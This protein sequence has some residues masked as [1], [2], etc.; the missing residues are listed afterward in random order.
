MIVPRA[1]LVTGA[2]G[3]IGVALCRNLA[4]RGTRVLAHARSK[5]KAEVVGNG[6]IAVWGDVTRD[7]DV[8]AI[9][10]QVVGHGGV[11]LVVHNAGVL[12]RD[13]R[14][15]PHGLGIQGEVNVLAP[16]T[17]TV[18]LDRA[19]ALHEG[20]TV[21]VNTSGAANLAR[22]H[23]YEALA[24]P[25][26]SSLFGHYALSKAAANALTAHLAAEFPRYT[27]AAVEPGFVRTDMT[28]ANPG[29][30]WLLGKLAPLF[31]AMPEKAAARVL[32]RALAGDFASGAVIQNGKV[33]SG[34]KWSGPGQLAAIRR[35]LLKAGVAD[36]A[37]PR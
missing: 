30:P 18:A 6:T 27:F 3:G 24:E 11:D 8:E 20:A 31:G 7:D 12:T 23:D 10:R 2:A 28:A 5:E 22:G 13:R 4:E 29:M 36:E 26:G 32:D 9:A 25:D 1:A 37:S 15:G 16:W 14:K 21:L 19:G 33:V 17:L 35:F 34:A